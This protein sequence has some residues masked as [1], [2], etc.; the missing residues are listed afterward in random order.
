[1]K[2]LK[3]LLTSCYFLVVYSGLLTAQ[4]TYTVNNID[5]TNDGVCN[6]AHCSLREAIIRSYADGVPSNIHFNIPGT[7]PHIIAPLKYLP[8]LLEDYTI[9]DGTTQPNYESGDIIID[10]QFIPNEDGIWI[11]SNYC[12]IKGLSIR[13]FSIGV[14]VI[15]DDAIIGE[16]NKENIFVNNRTGVLINNFPAAE[17]NIIQNNYFGTNTQNEDL[18][19]YSVGLNIQAQPNTI[20]NN[21]FGYNEQVGLLEALIDGSQNTYQG[22]QFFCNG[23]ALDL[24]NTMIIPTIT[25]TDYANK[26]VAGIAPENSFVDIYRSANASCET[27]TCQAFELLGT[28]W[29]SGTGDWGIANLNINIGDRILVQGKDGS[30]HISNF[31]ACELINDCTTNTITATLNL[32]TIEIGQ[33]YHIDAQP[34]GG[35]LPYL[36]HVWRQ[37]NTIGLVEL[38]DHDDGTVTI[39]GLRTGSVNIS[40]EV[41]DSEGCIVIVEQNVNIDIDCSAHQ[42]NGQTIEVVNTNDS[43]EGSLRHA[44]NCANSNAT[45][46]NIHFN[47]SGNK[48]FTIQLASELPILSDAGIVIDGTTQPNYQLGD[49]VIDGTNNPDIL[50]GISIATQHCEIYGLH[51]KRF[52]HSGIY[53]NQVP[54]NTTIGALNK[55]NLL[56]DNKIGISYAYFGTT[57]ISTTIS[58]NYIGTDEN[59]VDLGNFWEGINIQAPSADLNLTINQNTIAYNQRTGVFPQS[60]T[61]ITLSENSFLCNNLSIE[62]NNANQNKASPSIQNITTTINGVAVAND[63]IELFLADETCPYATCQGKTF[64]GNTTANA[65]GEW[66]FPTP[67]TLIDGDRL[68]A[69]ATDGSGNTSP[70][71]TC[72]IVLPDNCGIATSLSVND[73][74]CSTTGIV[75]DLKEMTDSEPVPN[76]ACSDSYAGR[77]A[78]YKVIIPETGNLLVRANLNN[79][80]EPV[81]EAY[82][83][84]CGNLILQQ[85]ELLDSIPFAMVFENY[86]AGTTL[87][88]RV[89]DK[90]N[91][92]VDSE[93]TALLHLTAH[94]LPLLK[95]DW[96]IC[97]QENNLINGNPMILSERDAIN[98][99]LEYDSTATPA[100]IAAIEAELQANGD[101]LLSECSC[102]STVPLQLWATDSPIDLE[103]RI[104]AMR[105]RPRPHTPN[106]NYTFEALEFQVNAYAIGHQY[107]PNIAMSSTGDFALVWTDEQRGH[108]YARVYK[109]SG[110]P[111]TQEFQVG[112]SDKMQLESSIAM[113]D[114]GDF[115]IV[116]QEAIDQQSNLFII[117][118]RQYNKDGSPKGIPFLIS[119]PASTTTS[120]ISIQENAQ[121]GTYPKVTSDSQGNFIVTWHHREQIYVQR[122]DN[123]ASLLG[124]IIEI[125]EDI[126]SNVQPNPMIAMNDS[127]DF[128]IV[129][130]GGDTDKNGIYTQRFNNTSDLL[131]D[132]FLVNGIEEKNQRNPDVALLND[133]SFIVVWESFEQEGIG[134]DYG[135][136]AQ[137]FN[138]DAVRIGNEFLVNTYKTANQSHPDVAL[139]DNGIFSVVWSSF[140]QD[141]YEEGI[142]GQLFDNRGQA[143]DQE[144][145]INSLDEPDQDKPKIATNGT[146]I[147]GIV[148]QDGGNDGFYTGVFGQR[149]EILENAGNVIFYPIST[150]TPST[151]LGDKLLFP[152]SI[153]QGTTTGQTAKIAIVDTGV[154]DEHPYLANALSN[155]SSYMD[156]CVEAGQSGYDFF[157]AHGMP[158]DVDGH[159]TKINGV[160]S[161][162]FDNEV[163]LEMMNLKFHEKG[164][165]KVF[166]AICAIY[167]AVNNGAQVLN[168]SWGFEASEF[169]SILY[170]ALKY[171]ADNDVLVVTTAGNTSK[172]NDKINK[173]PANFNLDNIIVVTAYEYKQSSSTIKLANYASYG[174]ETVDIAAYGFVETL[175]L[176]G[177]LEVA[178]GT[179]LAAPAVVNTAATIKGLYPILTAMDIKDC[180]LSSAQ[181]VQNLSDKVL[182]GGIL[183]HDMAL[184]C[185]MVKSDEI[186]SATTECQADLIIGNPITSRTY[187]S[188]TT[189]ESDGIIGVGN[190]TLFKAT[191][192]ITLL[193][194]FVVEQGA[195]F[196]AI[197]EA[198]EISYSPKDD[199][200][201]KNS[202]SLLT[203]IN[204]GSNTNLFDIAKVNIYPNPTS[205]DLVIELPNVGQENYLRL[206]DLLGN[207]IIYQVINSTKV[208]LNLSHLDSGVY[209]LYLNHEALGRVV[210]TR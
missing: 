122:F 161:R 203:N 11:E 202:S 130:S 97:D 190:N 201:E 196:L 120:D 197:I 15:G 24:R 88:L 204:D 80:I 134:L 30:N 48:P 127:G 9:I 128:I 117:K 137:R 160:I 56:T 208:N 94:K 18:R 188:N 129:W 164:E 118:G 151:L 125:G 89:W 167:Y 67:S 45:I 77:D 32:P 37:S 106:Y 141:G 52:A 116:W 121:Y 66:T 58:H 74:P 82:K 154:D 179:S 153:Y 159:G 90:E 69:T 157:N 165:G 91:T 115:V 198:C 21:I 169:P 72:F 185:A 50:S 38:T 61:G 162:N 107:A 136:Y 3:L 19:N 1:M 111:I 29:A 35:T 176:G 16:A 195:D 144:F 65:T 112:A 192:S 13:N 108:N 96:E 156:A 53:C 200:R 178:A 206:F 152:N 95:D 132:A 27:A 41:I 210:F 76:S 14:R 138:T 133:G 101:S 193:P 85:C 205:Q 177:G 79:T 191:E 44:I 26:A 168:L 93:N 78:W 209:M 102:N 105:K 171:A 148:W 59:M 8:T 51:L 36:S 146:S 113:D 140:G 60:T 187:H 147:L 62:L 54:D 31:S 104:R 143:I 23:T 189:I 182:T 109:S 46:D 98:F 124:T 119:G 110:N 123:N 135:I 114:A 34:T 71:S 163:Q 5:D 47:L 75:L 2:S 183:D 70:F 10:G 126:R 83:G 103:D 28:T 68:T 207:E 184:D 39:K 142:F 73:A 64:L 149:Y 100:E 20:R 4:I 63:K 7:G 158:I 12:Q 17:R 194:S 57:T 81:I 199:S 170:K 150:A 40:Y 84:D 181:A 33:T 139:F 6:T 186:L 43:G 87:Y 99:I 155:N 92:I 131:E 180:I 145:Q 42:I 172:D 166:D 175:K 55:S 174:Q 86:T 25:L 173:F 49:I 22:N